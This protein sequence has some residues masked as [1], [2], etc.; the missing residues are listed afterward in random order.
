MIPVTQA[1]ESL[2]NKFNALTNGQARPNLYE[3]QAWEFLKSFTEADMELVVKYI[4]LE[5][6]KND[7]K[8]SLR[9]SKLLDDLPRFNDLLSLAT[10]AQTRMK[11][12]T[13]TPKEQALFEAR[14]ADEQQPI[15]PPVKVS[16]EFLADSIRNLKQLQ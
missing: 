3:R 14:R 10:E 8:H 1:I 9:L 5:N 4:Q 7:Y 2:V 12:K 15:K 11:N 16:A 13:R 6:G